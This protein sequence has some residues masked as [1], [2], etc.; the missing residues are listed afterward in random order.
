M[1]SPALIIKE[2]LERGAVTAV[3]FSS[4]PTATIYK[5]VYKI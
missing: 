5:K 1:Y 3:N 4:T 2:A